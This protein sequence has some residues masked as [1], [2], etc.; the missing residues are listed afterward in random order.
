MTNIPQQ[1]PN[2]PSTSNNGFTES[3]QHRPQ[4]K[5]Y[6]TMPLLTAAQPMP[7]AD[8]EAALRAHRDFIKSGGAGGRWET[9]VT[10]ANTE[11]GIVFGI[12]LGAASA[13][14]EQA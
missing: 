3:G 10:D 14:G 13:A 4:P 11:S 6:S 5:R 2:K 8:F 7:P 1:P 12:Y 9:V